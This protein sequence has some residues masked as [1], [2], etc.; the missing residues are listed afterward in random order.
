MTIS[1][2]FSLFVGVVS[3]VTAVVSLLFAWRAVKVAERNNFVG[4]YSELHKIYQDP[5]TFNA[6]KVVWQLYSQY[7][8]NA[9]GKPITDQQALDIVSKLDR[10]SSEWKAIHYMSLFWKYV[11]ILVRKGYLDEEIAFEAFTSPNMLGLLAPNEKV[12]LE[13][14]YDTVICDKPPLLWLY[15]RWEKYAKS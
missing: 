1:V 5:Q 3:A 2:D 4:I 6:T 9:I 13:Y 8:G 10:D 11:S 14:H 15:N 7:E 12:F